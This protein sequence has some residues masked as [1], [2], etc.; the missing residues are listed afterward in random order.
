MKNHAVSIQWGQFFTKYKNY[1]QC[2]TTGKHSIIE[3]AEEKKESPP[4]KL[5]GVPTRSENIVVNE[6]INKN[7]EAFSFQHS[8]ANK[9]KESKNKIQEEDLN[10]IKDAKISVGTKCKRKGCNAVF[11]GEE[12]REEECH[13]H[14]GDPIFHEG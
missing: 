6:N 7:T 11:N 13:F 8:D 5:A 3:V 9:E 14:P 4:T 1:K 10:D 12:S 2:C